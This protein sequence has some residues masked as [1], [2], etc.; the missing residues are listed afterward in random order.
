MMTLFHYDI[1]QNKATAQMAKLIRSTPDLGLIISS[2]V[3]LLVVLLD[4]AMLRYLNN[5]KVGKPRTAVARSGFLQRIGIYCGFCEGEA[6]V[7]WPQ[8]T[9]RGRYSNPP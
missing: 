1:S 4:I 6:L 3:V 9:T 5:V 7:W 2:H 8:K